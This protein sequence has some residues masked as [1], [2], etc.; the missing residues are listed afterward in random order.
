MMRKLALVGLVGAAAVPT[1]AAAIPPGK[2][3]LTFDV[4]VAPFAHTV[5]LLDCSSERTVSLVSNPSSPTVKV[6]D[7]KDTMR[8]S[9]K[10]DDASM[11]LTTRSGYSGTMRVTHRDPS[12][13]RAN[14]DSG[15]AESFV[16]DYRSGRGVFTTAR[17][18]SEVDNE[19]LART[20][21]M[22]CT[23][24]SAR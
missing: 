23:P 16:L 6:V 7:A 3:V 24:K 2:A 18:V 12:T 19:L 14:A 17:N 8:W 5:T 22:R 21:F 11:T 10:L 15:V 1:L 13:L 9:A 20:H 4:P